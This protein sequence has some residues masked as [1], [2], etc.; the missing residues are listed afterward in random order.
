M[1]DHPGK[2][3]PDK[4]KT[5]NDGSYRAFEKFSYRVA[6]KIKEKEIAILRIRHVKQEPKEY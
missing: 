6:Y 4:F 5:D 3:P 1:A 2:Y